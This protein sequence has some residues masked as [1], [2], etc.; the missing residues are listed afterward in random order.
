MS[1]VCDCPYDE[2]CLNTQKGPHICRKEEDCCFCGKLVK[3][4]TKC[5][6]MFW[7]IPGDHGGHDKAHEVCLRLREMFADRVCGG[8]YVYGRWDFD[9]ASK[10]A[11]AHGD[12]PFWRGWLELYETTWEDE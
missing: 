6:D 9:E 7:F 1:N 10:H 3:A 12:D 2:G 8:G 5:Y 4:G 11:I